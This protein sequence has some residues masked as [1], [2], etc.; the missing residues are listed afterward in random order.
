MPWY[1]RHGKAATPITFE[2]FLRA[3]ERAKSIKPEHRA[4]AALLYY[5]G[6]RRGEALRAVKEQF[7]VKD[8]F[9][10]FDVG[11]RLKGGR[12]TPPLN[13]PLNA[14][15]VLDIWRVVKKTGKG[16]RVFPFT[17][18]TAYNIICRVF[19][20]YPHHL[21][22]SRITDFLMKG[23]NIAEVKSWTGHAST[24]SLDSYVGIVDVHR[25]GESLIGK[26]TK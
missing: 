17:D 21:R 26:P 12:E 4:F 25:M 10:F 18:R 19:N 3:M 24:K 13:I 6:V 1:R 16:E 9:L 20:T 23:F 5:T 15:Y 7:W 14:P 22:L 11:K 2:E 8:G